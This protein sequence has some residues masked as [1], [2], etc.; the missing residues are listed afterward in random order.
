MTLPQ[1]AERKYEALWRQVK[2]EKGL[3]VQLQPP[4]LTPEQAAKAFAT[5]K[6]AIS[7]E[8]YQ[9]MRYKTAYPRARLTF[10]LDEW[11]QVT[12]LL[13]DDTQ[14]RLEDL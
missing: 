5:I 10:K 4:N 8:K 12:F 14:P 1:Q 6:K 13:E 2:E 9:D 3:T 11:N 7:K